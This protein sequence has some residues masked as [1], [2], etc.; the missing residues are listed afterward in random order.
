MASGFYDVFK[1]DL[2]DGSVN[3]NASDTINV[4]LMTAAHPTTAGDLQTDATWADVS[5]NETSGAGYS[6]GGLALGTPTVVTATGTTTFDGDD[7]QWTGATFTC[8]H[9]VIYD[10]TNTNSLVATIDIGAQTVTAGTFTIQW[11]GS[12]IITMT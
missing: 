9:V 12:G 1:Q 10:I 7:T 4:A 5:A 2:F 3:L 8:E 11:N 6:A